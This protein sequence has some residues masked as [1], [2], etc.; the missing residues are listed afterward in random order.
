MS[1]KKEKMLSRR[2]FFQYTAAIV[3]I[4]AVTSGGY[5]RFKKSKKNVWLEDTIPRLNEAFRIK[6]LSEEKIELFTH[7]GK[8]V[9]IKHQFSGVEADFFREITKEQN[10]KVI[11]E[12]ISKKHGMTERLCLQKLATSIKEFEEARLI[13]YG[14]RMLV[15]I[16]EQRDER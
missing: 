6:E 2:D 15:K 5:F 7:N 9:I 4:S 1:K 10:L 13:Y 11:V 3:S 14:D 12:N 16:V 8:G